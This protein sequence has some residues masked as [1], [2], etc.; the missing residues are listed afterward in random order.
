MTIEDYYN[1]S[2]I[3]SFEDYSANTYDELADTTI[4]KVEFHV[5]QPRDNVWEQQAIGELDVQHD[6]TT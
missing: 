3:Y 4:L 5:D 1:F 6:Q 2:C